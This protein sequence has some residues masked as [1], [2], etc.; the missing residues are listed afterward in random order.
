MSSTREHQAFFIQPRPEAYP[1]EDLGMI[2]G[3]VTSFCWISNSG[4]TD[5]VLRVIPFLKS[6][7][8]TIIGMSGDRESTLA[9]N[10]DYHLDIGVEKEACP[11]QLAPTSSTTATLVMGDAL[12]SCI[13]EV[14]KF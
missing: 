1:W 6:N 3:R 7:G 11:L 9:K 14:E 8:N 10:S 12:A 4:E 13:D 2:R 5:E